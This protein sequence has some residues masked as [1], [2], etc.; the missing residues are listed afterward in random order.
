M[1]GSS[2]REGDRG[3]GSHGQEG[4]HTREVPLGELDTWERAHRHADERKR[5]GKGLEEGEGGRRPGAVHL[6]A[7]T[8]GLGV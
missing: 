1:T 4:V 6:F 8:Q 3:G 2:R 7:Q 5:P